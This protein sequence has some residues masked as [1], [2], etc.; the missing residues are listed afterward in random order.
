MS[1]ARPFDFRGLTIK[2][3]RFRQANL[4]AVCGHSLSQFDVEYGHHVVPNQCG[5]PADPSH[6]WIK[7]LINC[8]LLC[9]DCHNRVHENGRTKLGAVAPP[10]YFPFS[11]GSASRHHQKWVKD[12]E[13]KASAIWRYVRDRNKLT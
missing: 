6:Q 4:C 13:R 3:A 10:S 12:L 1:D 2:E 11:H 7:T 8:V 9:L 5:N